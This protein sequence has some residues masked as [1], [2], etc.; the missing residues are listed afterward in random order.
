MVDAGTSSR[1]RPLGITPVTVR[2]G[3]ALQY[4]LRLR[5]LTATQLA[6]FVFDGSGVSSRSQL[7]MTWRLIAALRRQGFVAITPRMIGGPGAGSD[8]PAYYLTAAGQRLARSVSPGARRARLKSPGTVL[9]RHAL[10]TADVLLAFRRNARSQ[11]GH[12]LVAWECDWQAAMALGSS[13]VVPDAYVLYRVAEQRLHAFIEIDL[14]T[15][16]TRLV[17]EKMRGYL[18][19]Q[20]AGSWRA[21]FP[22]WPLVLVVAET[23]ARV[24]QLR[25]VSESVLSR[26]AAGSGSAASS[27]R[28]A[29]LAEVTDEGGPLQNIWQVIGAVDRVTLAPPQVL[30]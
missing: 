22:V 2:E 29:R 7:V 1:I 27:F 8:R 28:F 9:V 4:L 10:A 18:E 13:L 14:G 26:E 16:H 3:A 5:F 30:I 11:A 21:R 12:E 19:L 6:E 25:R 20:R 23:D 17:A 24:V 15:E